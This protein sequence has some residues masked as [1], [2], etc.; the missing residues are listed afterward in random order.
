MTTTVAPATTKSSRL[1]EPRP[2]DVFVAFGITGDLAKVMTFMSLYRLERRGL[3]D[4]P[5]VGVAVDDWSV[6]QLKERARDSIEGAGEQLD[7]KVFERF[8]DRLSYVAGDFSDPATYEHVAAAIDGAESPVFY[9]EIPPFLFDP[10]GALRDV[11]VNHLMQLVA[12]AAMEVPS[13]ADP[14]TLKD[15]QVALFRAIADADPAHYVRGQYD[16]YREIDGVASDSQTETYAALRLDI[17]NWRWAGVPFFIRT[18]KKLPATQTELRLVFKHPPQLGFWDNAHRPEPNQLVVKLDPSTGVRLIVD[19][20]RAKTAAPE[21]IELD[22][23]FAEEGGEGA[24]PYEVLLHAAMIGDSKRFT[25][26]DGVEEAWRIM[27]PL[28]D[29]PPPV[30]AYAPGNWGPRAADKLVSGHGRWRDP[31]IPA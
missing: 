19:A 13:S 23:E 1:E 17:D 29:A 12:S 11:V 7:P 18:G 27:Q 28:L 10:V 22:M 25:R 14:D 15:A 24:A 16:G 21:P 30:H 4:C 31:W 6:D 9:L 2:A 26:Q 8:A 20:R 3:I 5:I